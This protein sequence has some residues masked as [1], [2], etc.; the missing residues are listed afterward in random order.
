MYDHLMSLNPALE[1]TLALDKNYLEETAVP[2]ITVS[3]SYREDV[4]GWYGL[5]EDESIQDIVFSRA[6][7][8]N[9][10]GW[11]GGCLEK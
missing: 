6:Q 2:I 10:T 1:K 7:L 8:L 5:P 3:A 11:S 9:G 4:K